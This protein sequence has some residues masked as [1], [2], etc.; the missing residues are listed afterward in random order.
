MKPPTFPLVPAMLDAWVERVNQLGADLRQGRLP[1]AEGPLRVAE[2]HAEFERIHPFLDGNGRT[3][4]LLLNL[5]MVRAGWPPVVIRKGQC[6]RYLAALIKA[7]TGDPDP[8]AEI[9]ARAAI[10]SMNA[11]LPTITETGE[12]V[13]LSALADQAISL[14]A[15]H[16]AALRGRLEASLDQKGHW[17][18]TRQAVEAYK[19]RRYIRE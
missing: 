10:A 17:R 9:I 7:D 15:L 14:Q 2:C 6:R 11:L 1:L 19:A 8:L 18:S 12:L 5:I 16:Q 13:P 4:R 3:G